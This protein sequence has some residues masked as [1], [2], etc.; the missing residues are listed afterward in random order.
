MLVSHQLIR[1]AGDRFTSDEKVKGLTQK[2][3]EQT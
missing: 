1:V 2:Q 3:A